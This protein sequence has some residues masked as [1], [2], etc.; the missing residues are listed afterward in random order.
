MQNFGYDIDEVI[1]EIVPKE[2]TDADPVD[3]KKNLNFLKD[4]TDIEVE[5]TA[6]DNNI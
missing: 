3:Q 5:E 2:E 4:F 1:D 6:Q